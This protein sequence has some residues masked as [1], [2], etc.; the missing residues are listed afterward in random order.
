MSIPKITDRSHEIV[1]PNLRNVQQQMVKEINTALAANAGV[2][3]VAATGSS[4]RNSPT[5]QPIPWVT[6]Q[7]FGAA[8]DGVR[9]DTTAIQAALNASKW[10]LVPTGTYLISSSLVVRLGSTIRGVPYW[11]QLHFT[12]TGPCLQIDNTSGGGADYDGCTISGLWLNGPGGS[13]ARGIEGKYNDSA[14][15]IAYGRFSDI[16]LQNFQIGVGGAFLTHLIEHCHFYNNLT[17]IYITPGAQAN[18]WTIRDCDIRSNVTGIITA[19]SGGRVIDCDIEA[20]STCAIV[21]AQEDVEIV[22][23]HIE[24]PSGATGIRFEGSGSVY[25]G[26]GRLDGGAVWLVDNTSIAIEIDGPNAR[27]ITLDSV[28]MIQ[29]LTGGVF[30]AVTPGTTG[31]PTGLIR[32]IDCQYLDSNSNPIGSPSLP[33]WS[34]FSSFTLPPIPWVTPQQFGARGD[35]TGDDTVAFQAALNASRWILVPA[36]T[37]PISASLTV[38]SATRIVGAGRCCAFV[39]STVVGP[40]FSLA[41]VTWPSFDPVNPN[42]TGVIEIMDLALSGPWM[43]GAPDATTAIACSTANGDGSAFST[44]SRLNVTA[45]SEGINGNCTTGLVSDCAFLGCNYGVHVGVTVGGLTCNFVTI[46]NRCVFNGCKSAGIFFD[47]S[48]NGIVADCD[49]ENGAAGAGIK[50]AGGGIIVDNCHIEGMLDGLYLGGECYCR[51]WTFIGGCTHGV[52]IDPA[53]TLSVT[54]RDVQFGTGS[55]VNTRDIHANGTYPSIPT[56]LIRAID[57]TYGTIP[58]VGAHNFMGGGLPA[59]SDYPFSATPDIPDYTNW[60]NFTEKDY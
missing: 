41:L 36:G 54:L 57:C 18:N 48:A 40:L 8:G 25:D 55:A 52:E 32:A 45:F 24:P 27:R 29:G 31:T 15:W 39:K 21:V 3:P 50:N 2:S 30:F 14:H 1:D 22:R 58:T 44:F 26:Q 23:C 28:I 51:N 53:N 19:G 33:S 12:G 60:H 10:V 13:G 16:L 9:D 4:T 20:N 56:G 34:G 43:G 38:R 59:T 42:I 49:L 47:G 46:N 5:A 37:Y 17:G 7:Q 35:G 11:S 6:P